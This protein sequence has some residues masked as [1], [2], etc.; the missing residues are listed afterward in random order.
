MR[1][2]RKLA[3]HEQLE[4]RIRPQRS[5]WVQLLLVVWRWRAEIVAVVVLVV[6]FA[7]LSDRLGSSTTA[8]VAMTAPVLVVL[9]IPVTRRFTLARAWCV[10]TRHRLRSCLVQVQATN[11]DGRLPW[12]LWARPTPVGER[13]WLWMLPGLSVLDLE[14][15]TEVIAAS[16]WAR[17]AR[18]HRTRRLATLVRVDVIRRDPLGRPRPIPNT[19]MHATKAFPPAEPAPVI[20]TGQGNRPK[21]AA[22]PTATN[23]T[24][25]APQPV[26]GGP[27]VLLNGEDVSDYV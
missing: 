8:L 17:D 18:V 23:P 11:R 22:Q 4:I 13:L 15:R 19:L 7:H 3:K 5:L 14:N 26:N 6:V 2:R 9:A 12:V 1:N 24:H 25:P 10:L 21:P 16:C 27:S 20:P